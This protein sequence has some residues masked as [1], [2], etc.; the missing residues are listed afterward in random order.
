[1]FNV[2]RFRSRG[3]GDTWQMRRAHLEAGRLRSHHNCILLTYLSFLLSLPLPVLVLRTTMRSVA[4][5]ALLAAAAVSSA[6]AATF[7]VCGHV[8]YCVMFDT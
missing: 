3:K 7:E 4:V 2:F 6:T 8:V 1:M 5:H